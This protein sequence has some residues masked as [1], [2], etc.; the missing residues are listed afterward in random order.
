MTIK[1]FDV[2]DDV[3][4]ATFNFKT[5]NCECKRM[6]V[7][8][9]G[10]KYLYIDPNMLFYSSV[11][12][13]FMEPKEKSKNYLVSESFYTNN[14]V[15]H[16]LCQYKDDAES[17]V[18]KWR[19]MCKVNGDNTDAVLNRYLNELNQKKLEK[20]IFYVYQDSFYGTELIG[21]A[22]TREKAE[23]IKA[24]RDEKWKPGFLWHTRI[25]EKKEKEFSCF[26]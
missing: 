9:V 4:V 8:N 11:G 6:V 18:N 25:S 15:K 10:R 1:D 24:E 2:Y 16:I 17:Y 26:D 23:E 14:N 7:T 13:R 12:E 19:S 5:H 22:E 3:Y 20:Q 21:T